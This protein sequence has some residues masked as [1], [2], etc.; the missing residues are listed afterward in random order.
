MLTR[1]TV[2]FSLR[3]AAL[4]AGLTG[5]GHTTFAQKIVDTEV[6]TTFH[7]TPAALLK[8]KYSSY[9]VE[10]DMGNVN[11]PVN[12]RPSLQSLPYQKDNPDL[13]LR[14][15]AK[16]LYV[17][18]RKVSEST[19]GVRGGYSG[20]YTVNYSCESGYELLDRKTEASLGSYHKNTGTVITRRFNNNVDLD[21]YM[22]N[23]FVA[24]Q[25]RQ[26]IDA[27]NRRADFDL[28]VH[29]YPVTLTLHTV[30]GP[31][32]AYQQLNQAVADFKAAAAAK[33][34]D[35]TK[36]QAI[37]SVWEQQLTHVNWEDKKSEINKK[38]ANALLENLCAASLL[39]EDYPKVKEYAAMFTSKN[40]GMFSRPLFFQADMSY[41]G[42][43]RAASP[44]LR[45]NIPNYV[46]PYYDNLAA[47]VLTQ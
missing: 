46:L 44:D 11:T 27:M 45:G 21:N 36:M 8:P 29:D 15:T 10:Y 19:G 20:S 40:T 35:K 14:V 43:A 26:V 3:N 4:L 9:V 47:D 16:N 38:V 28:N 12:S 33:P 2:S 41:A 6:A 7:K 30:E 23:T 34:V 31:A 1:F 37:A 24:D 39:L 22:A 18:D 42:T 17:T 25:S 32:P 5:L 13:L